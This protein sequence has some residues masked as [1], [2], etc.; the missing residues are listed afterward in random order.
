MIDIVARILGQRLERAKN[1]LTVAEETHA[2]LLDDLGGETLNS[3]SVS[4]KGNNDNTCSKN[5]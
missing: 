2:K 5:H 1:A 4:I 3:S